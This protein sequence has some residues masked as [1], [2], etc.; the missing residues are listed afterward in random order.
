MGLS[1]LKNLTM[2]RNLGVDGMAWRMK[3]VLHKL[4]GWSF[5]GT[6]DEKRGLIPN[7]VL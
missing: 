2:K 4:N 1:R 6:H 3:P 7:T 5:S